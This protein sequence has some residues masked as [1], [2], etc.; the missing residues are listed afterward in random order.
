MSFEEFIKPELLILIPV[1]YA[2]GI[3]LKKSRLSDT[4][5]PITL[6]IISVVLSASWVI[7]TSN[8]S[9]LK[10]VAF[11]IFTSVTQGILSAGASVYFNQLYVQSNKKE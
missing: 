10:D 9:S 6:G 11:A 7:A 1:L 4:L 2:V 3:G 8:I 5:I